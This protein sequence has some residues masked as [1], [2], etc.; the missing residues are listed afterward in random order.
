MCHAPRVVPNDAVR[1][2]CSDDEHLGRAGRGGL[3]GVSTQPLGLFDRS[4]GEGVDAMVIG[5]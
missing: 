1:A 2:V 3:T 5:K 4:T